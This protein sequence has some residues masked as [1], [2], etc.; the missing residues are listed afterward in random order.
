MTSKRVRT[1][2]S[3]KVTATP[4]ASAARSPRRATEP[5]PG[6]KCPICEFAFDD[7]IKKGKVIT[8]CPHCLEFVHEMCLKKSGCFCGGE[9]LEFTLG[10]N[11]MKSRGE[12]VDFSRCAN[13][14]IYDVFR[15]SKG[16]SLRIPWGEPDR[17]EFGEEV[18]N[19][20][21]A[22]YLRFCK[23]ASK[24]KMYLSNLSILKPQVTVLGQQIQSLITSNKTGAVADL[25]NIMLHSEGFNKHNPVLHS[26]IGLK[27]DK[28][29]DDLS[30]KGLLEEDVKKF[31]EAARDSAGKIIAENPSS[32][33][34]TVEKSGGNDKKSRKSKEDKFE[35]EVKDPEGL[36]NKYAKSFVGCFDVKLEQLNI[37]P[38]LRKKLNYFHTQETLL[39]LK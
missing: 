3:L 6:E 36:E 31:V 1:S 17:V 32:K 28:E 39:H 12:W 23:G 10:L 24:E 8:S 2:W 9:K 13:C 33:R 38:Y 25:L 7:P 37:D 19:G 18:V 30:I 22:P 35:E 11:W 26:K 14:S 20:V 4:A 27:A 5:G 16:S 34:K 21:P 29:K 15:R